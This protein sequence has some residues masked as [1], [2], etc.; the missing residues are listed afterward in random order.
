M[1]STH[2]T[3]LKNDINY[4]KYK[5]VVAY[6]AL[7]CCSFRHTDNIILFFLPQCNNFFLAPA[8]SLNKYGRTVLYL[9]RL[10]LRLFFSSSISSILLSYSPV[11]SKP[12]NMT[13][14]PYKEENVSRLFFFYLASSKRM[15]YNSFANPLSLASFF[16][17][18]LCCCGFCSLYPKDRIA[19][20]FN[21]GSSRLSIPDIPFLYL[22]SLPWD[23]P[24]L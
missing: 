12:S 4:V 2:T 9:E 14:L 15:A 20:Y 16:L 19:L 1:H 8:P 11:K 18:H 13:P 10:S 17:L 22:R 7:F 23:F 5:Y 21:S 3:V 24:K 6:P